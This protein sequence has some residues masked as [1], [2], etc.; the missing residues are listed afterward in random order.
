MV[1]QKGNVVEFRCNNWRSGHERAV[2]SRLALDGDLD[3]CSDP[4]LPEPM[5]CR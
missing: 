3:R 1:T 4:E 2:G 5:S